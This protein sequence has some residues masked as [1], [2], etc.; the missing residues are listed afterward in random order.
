MA[1]SISA[2]SRTE[3]GLTSTPTDRTTD[4]IM[5]NWP[6]PAGRVGSQRTAARVTPGAISLSSSSHFP[7]KPYFERHKA[8]RIAT[9]ARQTLDE[10]GADWIG[11]EHKY[12]WHGAGG[13]K[14]L[15]RGG[16]TSA[17]I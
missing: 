12:D 15:L 6:I 7:L 4:W 10:A 3:I 9:R 16:G 13:P 8:G 11:D 17:K 14:Q 5:A 1:R 2:A